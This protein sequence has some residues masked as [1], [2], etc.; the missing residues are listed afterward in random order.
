MKKVF[1]WI[2]VIIVG[3]VTLYTYLHPEYV[4]YYETQ[5]LAYADYD[6]NIPIGEENMLMKEM[7]PFVY[8]V[9]KTQGYL[10]AV[11]LIWWILDWK[12]SKRFFKKFDKTID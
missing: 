8:Y 2:L 3:Y 1:A 4:Q 7:N 9:L 12:R 11:G 6:E 10:I 5:P